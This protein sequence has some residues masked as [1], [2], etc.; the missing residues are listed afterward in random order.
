[1]DLCITFRAYA[2]QPETL[3]GIRPARSKPAQRSKIV[4]VKTTGK[5]PVIMEARAKV[6]PVVIEYHQAAPDDSDDNANRGLFK[7]LH[8]EIVL[9]DDTSLHDLLNRL[10]RQ[11]YITLPW[12]ANGANRY[13]VVDAMLA[14]REY[15]R[16]ADGSWNGLRGVLMQG[17]GQGAAKGVPRLRCRVVE[18]PEEKGDDRMNER[19]EMQKSEMEDRTR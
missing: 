1:M 6:V 3:F 19:E 8:D 16:I 5:L 17:A 15:I 18:F 11:N 4:T 9:R 7:T 10:T 14:N 13:T 12:L 2:E